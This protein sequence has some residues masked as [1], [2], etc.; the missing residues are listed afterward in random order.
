V[1]ARRIK[2]PVTAEPRSF[3]DGSIR[4]SRTD[5]R[6]LDF[7][8]PHMLLM[9]VLAV[10]SG[11][12]PLAYVNIP[13]PG[14]RDLDFY[15]EVARFYGLQFQYTP[16]PTVRE[17]GQIFF[18]KTKDRIEDA[19]ELISSGQH[20]TPKMYAIL[21]YPKCCS[22]FFSRYRDW[23]ANA[24]L[25]PFIEENTRR[26]APYDFVMNNLLNSAGRKGPGKDSLKRLIKTHVLP[27]HPC[28]YDCKESLA[29]GSLLWNFTQTICPDLASR[30]KDSLSKIV[31]YFNDGDCV[32]FD[33]RMINRR[34]C[35]Y[36][37]FEFP[38]AG[39]NGALKAAFG[40]GDVIALEPKQI[41]ILRGGKTRHRLPCRAPLLLDFSASKKL[42]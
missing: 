12:K 41:R 10:I 34:R 21:G 7:P 28:R 30:L 2:T 25:I 13:E 32:A 8:Y 18:A 14:Q 22:E 27:W 24:D 4:F 15:R 42:H 26:P 6:I 37:S 36:S 9:D 1:R 40:L 35:A 19:R 23:E 5:G 38:T 11:L 39:D 33:G 31:L 29:S 17:A 3:S 16:R 20:D